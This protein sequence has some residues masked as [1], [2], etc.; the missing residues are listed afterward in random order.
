ME[1]A[2]YGVLAT[3]NA[4]G[5]PCAVALNRV[6]IDDQTLVEDNDKARKHLDT[7]MTH[8]AGDATP[9]HLRSDY[10][11]ERLPGIAVIE[12]TIEHLTAKAYA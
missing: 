10:I 7:L 4:E 9:A 1:S 8:F 12:M 2:D 3:V 6:M 11:E 5:K